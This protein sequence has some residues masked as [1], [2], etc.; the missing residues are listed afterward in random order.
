MHDAGAMR[1]I[2]R[3]GHL[4]RITQ[5]RIER[6]RPFHQPRRERL[7]FEQFHDE[8]RLAVFRPD[9]VQLADVWVRQLRDRS[10][11]AL[12]AGARVGRR[13]DIGR[14]NLE[15]DGPSEPRVAR[16]VHFTHSARTER[17]HD[18]V[19]SK[20]DSGDHRHRSGGLGIQP[21]MTVTGL[22]PGGSGTTARNRLPSGDGSKSVQTLFGPKSPT[23]LPPAI[24]NSGAGDP[25]AM[26]APG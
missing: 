10:R 26:D 2:E 8:K 13:R 24:S 18:L 14:E 20:T 12:E 11:F 19:R 6:Q 15:S 25:S 1:G 17:R 21:I 5:R 7:A 22:R 3:V 16:A 4:R 23:A 9:V